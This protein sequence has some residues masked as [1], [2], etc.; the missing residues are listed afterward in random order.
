M[1]ELI[2]IIKILEPDEVNELNKHIDSLNF[3]RNSVFG[4]KGDT[5]V[6]DSIRTSTGTS[7]DDNHEIT[8]KFHTKINKGLDEYKRRVEK[9]H[10]NF[11]YYPIPQVIR[12][13][14]HG[15]RVY[16]YYNMK[17]R[18]NINFIM[19]QHKEENKKN[20]IVKYL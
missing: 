6:V 8:Q 3:N 20:I 7:L 13:R 9:I 17:R 14:D 4:E 16:K 11:S 10:Y 5:S 15:E 12:G 18:K 19:M 1:N 2:Q